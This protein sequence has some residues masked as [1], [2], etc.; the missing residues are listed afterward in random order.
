MKS[1]VPFVI[2]YRA[3]GV[4]QSPLPAGLAG[5][6]QRRAL[7]AVE[8]TEISQA[9]SPLSGFEEVRN[10]MWSAASRQAQQE[11]ES[12]WKT[13][14]K[15]IRER[16]ALEAEIY[17]ERQRQRAIDQELY[18][19]HRQQEQLNDRAALSEQGLEPEMIGLISLVLPVMGG[20]VAPI[21]H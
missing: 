16:L 21:L 20:T 13:R 15:K 9:G 4:G 8:D 5:T 19:Q 10:R 3:S 17:A 11:K 12:Y 6:L 18:A 7:R 14:S 1:D 2:A